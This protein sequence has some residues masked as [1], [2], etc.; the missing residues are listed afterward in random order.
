[1]SQMMTATEKARAATRRFVASTAFVVVVMATY[2]LGT[3]VNWGLWGVGVYGTAA[4]LAVF[5]VAA[6]LS[7]SSLFATPFLNLWDS[8]AENKRSCHDEA[9][10]RNQK[11]HPLGRS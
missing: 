1:M 2:L 9:H 5:G 8:A 7:V 11:H 3:F 10:E 6:L 4:F